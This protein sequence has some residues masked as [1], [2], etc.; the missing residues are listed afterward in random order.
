MLML[1]TAL[2]TSLYILVIVGQVLFSSRA[3]EMTELII[4]VSIHKENIGAAMAFLSSP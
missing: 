3:I 2:A 1:C 4:I